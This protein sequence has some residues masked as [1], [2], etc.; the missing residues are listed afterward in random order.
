[1]VLNVGL[2]SV[3]RLKPT[4]KNI[5]RKEGGRETELPDNTERA[6]SSNELVSVVLPIAVETKLN[7]FTFFDF[8]TTQMCI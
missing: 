8:R 5:Y 4:R 6:G 3:K 1:M 2:I 7:L